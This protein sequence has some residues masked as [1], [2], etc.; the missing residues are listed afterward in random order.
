MDRDG[1]VR[2]RDFRQGNANG[3]DQSGGTKEQLKPMDASTAPNQ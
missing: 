1:P 2:I 3:A